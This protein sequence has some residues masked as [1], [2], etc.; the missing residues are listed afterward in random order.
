MTTYKF[1]KRTV[2]ML[3]DRAWYVQGDNGAFIDN[4]TE[5]ESMVFTF[6]LNAIASK[7]QLIDHSFTHSIVYDGPV[8]L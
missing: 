2:S 7:H 1:H 8:E 4:L 6:A 3:G 5:T